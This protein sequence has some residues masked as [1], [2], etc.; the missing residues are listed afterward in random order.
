MGL[1]NAASS[2]VLPLGHNRYNRPLGPNRRTRRPH[3]PFST[4]HAIP[5]D[6]ALVR[7]SPFQSPCTGV[8]PDLPQRCSDCPRC[9]LATS[10][11]VELS[12]VRCSAAA[13]IPAGRAR[14]RHRASV[15]VGGDFAYVMLIGGGDIDVARLPPG[16]V[17]LTLNRY[18]GAAEPSNGPPSATNVLIPPNASSWTHSAGYVVGWQIPGTRTRLVFPAW[19]VRIRFTTPQG[20]H[21]GTL[22][23]FHD[24]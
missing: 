8:S 23:Q 17:F 20:P 12:V 5:E 13:R 6:T 10:E 24:F 9:P 19:P 15:V 7:L 2:Y 22:F 1:S 4:P 14:A 16:R 21:T 3:C 18:T 11:R